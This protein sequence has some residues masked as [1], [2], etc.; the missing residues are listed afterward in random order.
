MQ[1]EQRDNQYIK[2]RT[3][4]QTC[5]RHESQAVALWGAV[6]SSWILKF[7]TRSRSTT[8]LSVLW[9][10]KTVL[11]SFRVGDSW[12][13]DY[14]V[15]NMWCS[16]NRKVNGDDCEPTIYIPDIH[17]IYRFV[18]IRTGSQNHWPIRT[19]NRT[20]S[21]CH[22]R[23]TEPRLRNC[24]PSLVSE[25]RA[26]DSGLAFPWHSLCRRLELI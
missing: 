20:I 3:T 13:R 12:T 18:R 22:E 1:W 26:H 24:I 25:M 19:S 8:I 16:S 14:L 9:C 11:A 5:A 4:P 2:N 17:I 21:P 23:W 6:S 15:R 7:E 10:N